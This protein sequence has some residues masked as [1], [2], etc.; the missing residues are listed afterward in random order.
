VLS[1]WLRIVRTRAAGPPASIQDRARSPESPHEP[2]VNI[3]LCWLAPWWPVSASGRGTREPIAPWWHRAA[4]GDRAG[5][6]AAS[7]VVAYLSMGLPA[8]LA[9][10][11]DIGLRSP[12]GALV[13]S[14][15]IAVLVATTGASMLIHRRPAT[16]RP[17]PAAAQAET[18]PETPPGPARSRRACLEP[19]RT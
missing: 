1:H 2:D 11:S 8:V 18:P 6:V 15:V 5:L 3:P 7:Y 12:R 13:Y 9:G 4:P 16:F 17:E 14:V 19:C 10:G